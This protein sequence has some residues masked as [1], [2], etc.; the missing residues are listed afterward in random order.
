M[1][2]EYSQGGVTGQQKWE[3]LGNHPVFTVV[4]VI[5][6]CVERIWIIRFTT[7]FLYNIYKKLGG[8]ENSPDSLN[9]MVNYHYHGKNRVITR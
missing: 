6:H 7:I 3:L 2:Y 5:Y 1:A 4:M 8:N 9:A